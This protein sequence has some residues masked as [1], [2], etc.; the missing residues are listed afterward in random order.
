MVLAYY[1]LEKFEDARRSM[2]R[3]LTFAEKFRMDNH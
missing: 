1:R 3:L 2:R